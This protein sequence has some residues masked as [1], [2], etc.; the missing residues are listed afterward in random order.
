MKYMGCV[1]DH[2]FKLAIMELFPNRKSYHSDQ[3]KRKKMMHEKEDI[4]ELAADYHDRE[5]VAHHGYPGAD[6]SH[7]RWAKAR[8]YHLFGYCSVND[9]NVRPAGD[10]YDLVAKIR[11]SK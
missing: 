6:L 11:K 4:P 8:S 1:T 2:S 9:K 3:F 7:P 5:A 10:L